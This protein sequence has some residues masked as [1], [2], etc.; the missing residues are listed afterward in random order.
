MP[1]IRVIEEPEATGRLKEI[2]D[3]VH[4]RRGSVADILKVHSLLPDTLHAHLEF[5]IAVQF[6]KNSTQGLGRPDREMLAVVVSSANDCAY[7]VAH[8]ADALMKYWKDAERVA[9]LTEDYKTAGLS[10][11]EAAL[12]K[13]AIRLTKLPGRSSTM[14]VAELRREGL[15]DEAILQ[16]TLTVGYFNFVNRLA[17]ATGIDPANDV[18]KPYDY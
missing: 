7:C 13:Y 15:S 9:R 17:L 3:E 8:H 10:P 2:Y 18:A 14:D 11:R 1:T 12:C 4:K 6:G 16:A 5:Y